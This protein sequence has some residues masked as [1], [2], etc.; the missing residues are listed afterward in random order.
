MHVCTGSLR[1]QKRVSES[2]TLW[3]AMSYLMWVFRTS[4]RAASIYSAGEMV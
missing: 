4:A 2:L 3:V 1:R